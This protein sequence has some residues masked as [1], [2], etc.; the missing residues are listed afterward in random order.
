[1]NNSPFPLQDMLKQFFLRWTGERMIKDFEPSVGFFIWNK[2]NVGY[3]YLPPQFL[4]Q[5]PPTTWAKATM[6][7]I[8]L[9]AILAVSPLTDQDR[10]VGYSNTGYL[11]NHNKQHQ[12]SMV[13]TRVN[14]IG[15]VFTLFPLSYLAPA[16][17]FIYAGEPSRVLRFT[18]FIQSLALSKYPTR[19]K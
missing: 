15:N 17:K 3:G 13:L 12:R 6:M 1:M 8:S 16:L 9:K 2:L 18:P 11:N 5:I 14:F 4:T 7:K 10:M 19:N